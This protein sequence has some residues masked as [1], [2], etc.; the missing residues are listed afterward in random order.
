MSVTTRINAPQ[1]CVI[2]VPVNGEIEPDCESSLREL[3]RRGYPVWRVR[4]YSAI[5]QGRNQMAT[6]ALA[7]GFEETLWIDADIS[8]NP[9]D[10]DQLRSL[11]EPISCGIYAKKGRRELAIHVLPDTEKIVF[12]LRGGPM[13]IKYAATGFLHV[14]REVYDRIQLDLQ[15]PTCNTRWN[16]PLVPYF[17]PMIK[18]EDWGHW[19]LAEDYA[20]SERARSCGFRIVADTRIRLGHIGKYTYKWEEA[21]SEVK[22]F[23]TFT[24]HL[25]GKSSAPPGVT[26]PEA[27]P[28]TEFCDT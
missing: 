25:K 6:D 20:F 18:S 4:G 22:R 3:E 28:L 8:F 1:R 24:Y 9:S 13:E 5:D 21:G 15:L 2:L 16:K 23:A 10:V 7:K 11:G 17:Q 27:L 26:A 12:G 19:Y 14:R